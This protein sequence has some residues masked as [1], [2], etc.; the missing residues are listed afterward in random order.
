MHSVLEVNSLEHHSQERN[1]SAA[2]AIQQEVEI[3]PKNGTEADAD[4]TQE[5]A[6][7]RVSP[8]HHYR[9]ACALQ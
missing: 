8:H 3:L 4:N 6:R 9:T 2:V 1:G 7:G 5:T